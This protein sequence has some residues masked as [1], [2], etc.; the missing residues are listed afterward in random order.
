MCSP[1]LLFYSTLLI[2][3]NEQTLR[4]T[5]N[6]RF[7]L[8]CYWPRPRANKLFVC[9]FKGMF[10]TPINHLSTAHQSTR[11]I[12]I[13]YTHLDILAVTY[14]LLLN[15]ITKMFL[16]YYHLVKNLRYEFFCTYSWPQDPVSWRLQTDLFSAH[17]HQVLIGKV[18]CDKTGYTEQDITHQQI[19]IHTQKPKKIERYPHISSK[20]F[21]LRCQ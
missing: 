20:K 14:S 4:P 19:E 18:Q 5:P 10:V 9:L 13:I 21:H 3:I 6:T 17:V 15:T 2:E 7:F 12:C 16:F 8:K 1:P 11:N